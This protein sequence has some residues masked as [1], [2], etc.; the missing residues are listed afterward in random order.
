MFL[1][2]A[3]HLTWFIYVWDKFLMHSVQCASFSND[4]LF[5]LFS[6]FTSTNTNTDTLESVTKFAQADVC[7]C[8]MIVCFVQY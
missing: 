2:I 3:Q 4:T 7:V 8:V 5:T 1:Y 6:I